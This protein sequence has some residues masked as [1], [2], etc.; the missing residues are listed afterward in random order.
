MKFLFVFIGLGFICY[1]I[2]RCDK[3]NQDCVSVKTETSIV[4]SLKTDSLK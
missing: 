3:E 2:N 1:G 4:D